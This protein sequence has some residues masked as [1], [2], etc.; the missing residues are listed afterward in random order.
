MSLVYLRLR[1]KRVGVFVSA[2]KFRV[3]S[4]FS[5][6]RT[7]LAVGLKYITFIMLKYNLYYTVLLFLVSLGIFILKDYWMNIK[8]LFTLTGLTEWFPP[9]HLYL[10]AIDNYLSWMRAFSGW[11]QCIQVHELHVLLNSASSNIT[12]NLCACVHWGKYFDNVHLLLCP[13]GLGIRVSHTS[14]DELASG[15]SVLFYG[16]VW[17]PLTLPF[18]CMFSRIQQ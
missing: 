1:S 8:G 14:W 15:L 11:N 5:P 2:P 4:L 10:C 9:C 12:E 6:V 3:M 13:S 18:L 16:G 7:L 17:R